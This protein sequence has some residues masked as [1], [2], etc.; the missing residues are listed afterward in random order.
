MTLEQ[1][2]LLTLAVVVLGLLATYAGDISTYVSN[3]LGTL[4]G[5]GN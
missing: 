1:V 3:E 4:L 2:L 5:G